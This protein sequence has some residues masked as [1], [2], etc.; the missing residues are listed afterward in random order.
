M[1]NKNRNIKA[2][3][4]VFSVCLLRI[5]VLRTFVLFCVFVCGRANLLWCP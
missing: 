5:G 3:K 4:Q 1:I 2:Q